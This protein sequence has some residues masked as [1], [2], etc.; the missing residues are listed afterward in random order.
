MATKLTLEANITHALKQQLTG[1]NLLAPTVEITNLAEELTKVVFEQ[2]QEAGLD[3][4]TWATIDVAE[5]RTAVKGA[6]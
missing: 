2:L 3:L 5:K 4:A 1:T 6:A